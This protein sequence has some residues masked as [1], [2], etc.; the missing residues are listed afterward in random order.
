[1]KNLSEAQMNALLKMAGSKLGT[2]PEALKQ[3][4][5]TGKLD[6]HILQNMGANGDKLQQVL[7]HPELANQML[8]SPEAQQLL[9]QLFGKK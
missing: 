4:L 6:P 1:M 3:Q 8:N 2:S 9:K 7:Q 5:S